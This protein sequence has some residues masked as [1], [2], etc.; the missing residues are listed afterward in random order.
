MKVSELSPEEYHPYFKPYIDK[1]GN[2]RLLKSLKKGKK[3][4]IKFFKKLPTSK[5]EY[6]YEDEKWTPKDILL[7]LID[8]ER[9]FNYR[10]LQVARAENV[11]LEGFDENE[12]AKNA[13]ANTRSLKNLLKEYK[14][15]RKSSINFFKNTTENDFLKTGKANN[16]TLSVR[17][18]G[19]LICGHEIHHI[20]T[21]KERYL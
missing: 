2:D 17:A 14:S 21:I 6:Q 7:H 9:T 12:F 20:Q 18:V 19:F 3:K 10:A 5:L 16:N 15:V 8:S 13:N 1:V 11:N 4:T